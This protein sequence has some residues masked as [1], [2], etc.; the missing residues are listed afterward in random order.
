[1]ADHVELDL[2]IEEVVIDSADVVPVGLDLIDESV[3]I[4]YVDGEVVL[5]VV[6][7]VGPR[8]PQGIQGEVGPAGPPSMS[9]Y[10]HHQTSASDKWLIVHDLFYPPAVTVVDSAGTVLIPD[11]YYLDDFHISVEFSYPTAGYAYCT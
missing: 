3:T 9:F 5:E 4:E 7:E 2:D 6:G 10:R 8:G 1:M 11:V